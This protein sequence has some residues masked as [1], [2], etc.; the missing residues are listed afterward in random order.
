MGFHTE[1]CVGFTEQTIL[2]GYRFE[3]SKKL[4]KNLTILRKD[5]L[6]LIN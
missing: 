4:S 6:R 1:R 5:L 3:E 2:L